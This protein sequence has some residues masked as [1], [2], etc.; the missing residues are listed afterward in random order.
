VADAPGDE[1]RL[2]EVVEN[3]DD[4]VPVGGDV[5]DGARELAVDAY[6]LPPRLTHAGIRLKETG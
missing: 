2:V 6:H 3:V 5:H 1:E 4:D